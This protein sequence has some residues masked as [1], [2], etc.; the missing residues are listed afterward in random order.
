MGYAGL[1]VIAWEMARGL[2]AKGHTVSMIAADGSTCPGVEII[3]VGPERMVDEAAAYGGFGE[4]K[5]G[6]RVLREKH[7]GYW[8]HLLN[9][10]VIIDHSWSKYAYM[11][12]AEGRLKAPVLGVLHAPVATMYQALPPVEKPCFVCI[13]QDQANHFEAL[14]SPARAR[15]CYNGIDLN[16]Y[17]PLQIPRS[18]RFLFLARFSTV[19]SPDVSIRI[20]KQVGVSLDLVGDTSITNEPQLLD[21]CMR[22]CDGKQ[23]RMV[24]PSSRGNCVWWFSQAHA[25]VHHNNRFREPFG[26]A[27]VEAMACGAPVLGWRYGAMPE[28][29]RHG[30]T[31]FLAETYDEAVAYVRAFNEGKTEHGRKVMRENCVDWAQTFSIDNMVNRYEELCEEAIATGGW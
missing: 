6:D 11:L 15:V 8:Q 22:M 7:L 20:C 18:N 9:M 23:I 2:A 24:G 5:D 13:S 26:L 30:E 29:V 28:T 16:V 10:D 1:E 19:K 4:M 21:E 14:F 31:G 25:L 3:P 17:K 27:P 12:K